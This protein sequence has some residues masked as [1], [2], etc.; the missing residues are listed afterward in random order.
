MLVAQPIGRAWGHGRKPHCRETV[1]LELLLQAP[2]HIK[3][4][5]APKRREE[6][7]QS[8]ASKVSGTAEET[9]EEVLQ[10]L[11]QKICLPPSPKLQ[12]TAESTDVCLVRVS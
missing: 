11:P 4:K 2:K 6:T 9:V 8:S 3:V 1:W 12:E 10:Q 5:E 7:Q